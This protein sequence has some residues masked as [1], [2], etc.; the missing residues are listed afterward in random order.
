MFGQLTPVGRAYRG[1]D[2]EREN[3]YAQLVG[4]IEFAAK[5]YMCEK[6]ASKATGGDGWADDQVL[7]RLLDLNPARTDAANTTAEGTV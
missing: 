7:A 3:Q 2:I 1:R 6:G 5:W 4:A